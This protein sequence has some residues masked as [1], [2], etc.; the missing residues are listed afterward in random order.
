MSTA[1]GPLEH[2]NVLDLTRMYPGAFG[3]LLLADLGADVV[4]VESPG[5]G[6][7]I[8]PLT[9]TGS[10]NHVHVALNRGKRSVVLDLRHP[11]AQTVLEH[12]VDW[13]DIVTESHRPGQLDRF[14]LGY[15]AMQAVNPRVIW[16]SITG[17]GEVGPNADVPGHDLTFMGYSGMLSRL[18]VGETQAHDTHISLP[19][20]GMMAV[21]GVLAAVAEGERTGRGARLDVNMC[22][23]AIWTMSDE[24]AKAA[25]RPGPGWG[26]FVSRNVYTCADGRQ[27]K[28]RD[29]A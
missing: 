27:V 9:P 6:D 8:R 29:V 10:F 18:S 2:L 13:A 3:T 21:I 7:G 11:D 5:T 19:L 25:R 23:S 24:I 4:K 26:A 12:L 16:C 20:A 1:G 14:G 28:P 22:D 17:F 15:E